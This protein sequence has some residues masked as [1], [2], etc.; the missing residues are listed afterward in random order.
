MVWFVV[1]LI[2]MV[3]ILTIFFVLLKRRLRDKIESEAFLNKLLAGFGI[4]LDTEK[5]GIS[6][7]IDN[8]LTYINSILLEHSNLL[9]IDIKSRKELDEL[10]AHPEKYLVI[11]DVIT[12]IKKRREANVQEYYG[13]WR[14]EIGQKYIEIKYIRRFLDGK[15]YVVLTTRD[16]SHELSNLET[17][18]L[19]E[20]NEIFEEEIS[21]ESISLYE[22]GDRIR[23]I[24]NKHGLVDIFG[25]GL[26]RTNGEI[27]FPYFKYADEDDRSGLVMSPSEKTMSRY[28]IDK[29]LKLHIESA[30]KQ[31]D[32]GDGY[33][34]KKI[35]G[36]DFTIYGVPIIFRG[37][38]RGVILFEKQ[39]TEQFSNATLAVFDKVAH[40]IFLALRF[41]DILEELEDEK[42]KLL[43]VSIKD[44]LTGAYSRL[45]LEQFLE[46]ELSK[47]KR[48]NSKTAV[49]FLDVNEF[50][51][52]NDTYGHVY[53][54]KILKTLV[55]VI[56]KNIR[57]MDLVARYG[58][59]EFVIVLP[60]T[61]PENA[62]LVM[63]RIVEAL[64]EKN[65]S[66]S[67]GMIE[68]SEFATIED[69]YKEVDRRMYEMKKKSKQE[70]SAED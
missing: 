8:D 57:I 39:G 3:T 13:S 59:D 44:Y 66:I 30:L 9:G 55:E 49:A 50:K 40:F 45:F 64:G 61:T 43:E 15:Q 2:S 32:L 67:Y 25:V 19:A 41:I 1:F 18:I 11:Y 53:G 38:T 27:Y 70:N 31:Q 22:F 47:C 29:G 20:L 68:I 51:R 5:L 37:Q 7:W 65:I 60:E 33:R 12:E 63:K 26:L 58:G 56:Y 6:I 4:V 54:D 24:L 48:T 10:F 69:I 16:V 52:I 17:T 35:R 46:K 34:L 62:G 21:K 28:I 23:T 14:K 36:E 42:K